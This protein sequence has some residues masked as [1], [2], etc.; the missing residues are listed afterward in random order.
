MKSKHEHELCKKTCHYVHTFTY[1]ENGSR[2]LTTLNVPKH[3]VSDDSSLEL[4]AFSS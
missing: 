3:S 1:P 2:D 4:I